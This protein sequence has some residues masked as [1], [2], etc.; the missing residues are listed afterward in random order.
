MI[1]SSRRHC[2]SKTFGYVTPDSLVPILNAAPTDPTST[3]GY[4]VIGVEVWGY[5]VEDIVGVVGR[6]NASRVRVV[7][8]DEYVACLK[9]DALPLG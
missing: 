5:G 7:G 3:S 1:V 9:R 4:S 2:L 6:L 8:I